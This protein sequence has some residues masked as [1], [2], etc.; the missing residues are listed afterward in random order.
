MSTADPH[1]GQPV[2]ATGAPLAEARAAAIFIHGRG[3][4]AENILGL[5]PSIAGRAF[6][7][8]APQAAGHVWYPYSFLVPRQRNEPGLSSALSVIGRI[9]ARL[10]Q[11]GLSPE[12]IALI[13][14]SQ[15]AC[16]AAE[17]VA[18]NPR[19]YGAVG[20]FSGGLI[21]DA[22]EPAGYSGSLDG[23]PVFLGCS[24]VDPHIPLER[25]Q[26]S[27]AILSA[28]GAEVT[29]R[30]YPGM[31]HTIIEEEAAFVRGLLDRMLEDDPRAA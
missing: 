27:T 13:G 6:A 20:G 16:L 4:S 22:I 8:L 18:R 12:R 7:C 24:D 28:M 31:G 30:I 29:E 1:R 2:L 3:A 9:V 17:F 26:Q 19:R 25:V 14:F 23:T 21:G 15:G 5:A 11:A 10:G